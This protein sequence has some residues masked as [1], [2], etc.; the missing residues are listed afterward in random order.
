MGFLSP[1]SDRAWSALRTGWELDEHQARRTECVER[2]EA[3]RRI[4]ALWPEGSNA[5]VQTQRRAELAKLAARRSLPPKARR[6]A[7]TGWWAKSSPT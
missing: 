6:R 5:L 7:W 1:L 2:I 3:R 4:D